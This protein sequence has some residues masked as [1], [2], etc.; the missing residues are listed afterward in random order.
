MGRGVD[1]IK[2][3]PLISRPENFFPHMWGLGPVS[4]KQKTPFFS[5][6]ACG[7]SP[8][9]RKKKKTLHLLPF[10]VSRRVRRNDLLSPLVS[11]ISTFLTDTQTQ[12][13]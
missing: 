11:A 2:I 9:K 10:S 8:K 7:N 5:S 6:P 13:E 12:R 4:F 1:K 3:P